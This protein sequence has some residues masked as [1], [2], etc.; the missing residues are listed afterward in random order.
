MK[1][2]RFNCISGK[3]EDIGSTQACVQF[4]EWHDR[5][6]LDLHFYSKFDDEIKTISLTKDE[7]HL[8]ALVMSATKYVDV[9]SVETE[10]TEI[11]E[12]S[13]NRRKE[14]EIKEQMAIIPSPL[15]GLIDYGKLSLLDE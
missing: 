9:S 8:L 1:D 4:N 7:L 2:I 6:G 14:R 12:T 11:I 5:A 15:T 10:A 13:E 3:I